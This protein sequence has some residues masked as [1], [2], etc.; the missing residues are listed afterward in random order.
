MSHGIVVIEG[1]GQSVWMGDGGT[2]VR[3]GEK[4]KKCVHILATG[5]IMTVACPAFEWNACGVA[6]CDCCGGYGIY[7]R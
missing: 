3:K 5:V 2:Q 7:C 6:V 1:R 4:K